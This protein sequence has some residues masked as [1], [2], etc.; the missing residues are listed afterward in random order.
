MPE[1][2]VGA[3]LAHDTPINVECLSIGVAKT[4]YPT[5]STAPTELLQAGRF[6]LLQSLPHKDFIQLLLPAWL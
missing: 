6:W 5:S 2:G 1:K 3:G 4:N